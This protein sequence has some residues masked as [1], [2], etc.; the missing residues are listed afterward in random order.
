MCRFWA[1]KLPD[2]RSCGCRKAEEVADGKQKKAFSSPCS[3]FESC[4]QSVLHCRV[5]IGIHFFCLPKIWTSK[6]N[7]FCKKKYAKRK[8]HLRFVEL[9]NLS[10]SKGAQTAPIRTFRAARVLQEASN[11]HFDACVTEAHHSDI[12]IF[13]TRL[14]LPW[15]KGKCEFAFFAFL[16]F[17]PEILGASVEVFVHVRVCSVFLHFFLPCICKDVLKVRLC[18]D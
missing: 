5:K 14:K 2:S 12:R 1:G 10:L 18:L 17:L 15:T 16:F 4:L 11:G 13:P 8:L 3:V 7:Y 9:Q 6:K